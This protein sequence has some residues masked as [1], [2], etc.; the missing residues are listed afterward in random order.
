M[1]LLLL[2][3]SIIPLLLSPAHA[4]NVVALPSS[5]PV[6]I[7]INSEVGTTVRFPMDIL[8]VTPLTSFKTTKVSSRYLQIEYTGNGRQM[9]HI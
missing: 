7:Y 4:G 5:S 3:L 6:D 1:K 9:Q 2:I 8:L